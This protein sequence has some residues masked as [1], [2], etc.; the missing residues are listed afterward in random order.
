MSLKV[1]ALKPGEL[2]PLDRDGLL[3]F[4]ALCALRVEEWIPPEA[5]AR[6]TA[7]LTAVVDHAAVGA[8][9][10][11]D[12]PARSRELSDLGATASHAKASVDEPVG[13][14]HNYALLTAAIAL[15]LIPIADRPT[16][17]KRVIV[18]AKHAGSIPALLAN[19]GRVIAPA[20]HDPVDFACT[21]F[22]DARRADVVRVAA[23]RAA[24]RAASD[25]L[26]ALRAL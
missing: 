17:V 3:I 16:I 26:A 1:W 2:K 21:Q 7:A 8:A 19:A 14:C 15:E 5:R 13:R 11:A 25:R 12:I 23:Q 22:W 20:G 10:P 6:F 24:L 9:P 4:T 18:A